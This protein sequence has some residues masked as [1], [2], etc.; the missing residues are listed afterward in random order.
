MTTYVEELGR[1]LSDI[2]LQLWNNE[3]F[4]PN[5]CK[6]YQDLWRAEHQNSKIK[7]SE[8]N[9]FLNTPTAVKAT[10]P[11]KLPIVRPNR[12]EFLENR[13]EYKHGCGGWRCKHGCE[14]G[15]PA[16]PGE[17]C[18]TCTLYEDSGRKF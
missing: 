8:N 14:H 15:L 3:Y 13:V 5:L 7:A 4:H 10:A 1:E 6:Y 2:E 17:Y 16:V 12:C 9:N 11:I 18:Q